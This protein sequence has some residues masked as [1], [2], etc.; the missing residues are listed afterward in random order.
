MLQIHR[1]RPTPR[2]ISAVLIPLALL[3]TSPTRGTAAE[4][5]RLFYERDFLGNSAVI[6]GSADVVVFDLESAER[7]GRN[8]ARYQFDEGSYIFCLG[9]SDP[10]LT[11]LILEDA[12]GTGVVHL[13]RGKRQKSGPRCASVTLPAGSYA[14]RV[15]HDGRKTGDSRRIAFAHPAPKS[16]RLVDSK[17]KPLGGWWALRPDSSLDP[18]IRE[19]RVAVAAPLGDSFWSTTGSM[20]VVRD[21]PT[22][23]LLSSGEVLIAG[24]WGQG[25][26][27]LDSTELYDAVTGQWTSSGPM[28]TVRVFH[29]ATLLPSGQVLVA[30]GWGRRGIITLASA[31][32]YDPVTRQWTPTG[33]MQSAR[34]GHTATL[35][36]GGKVLVA[37]GVDGQGNRLSSAELYDPSTGRW[38]FTADSLGTTH[39]GSATLLPSGDVLFAG[40][41]SLGGITLASAEVYNPAT[42][43]WSPTFQPMNAPRSGHTATL[44]LSGQVLIT[45]GGQ[46]DSAEI[47]DPATRRW[48]LTGSMTTGR[49]N[50]TA[51]LLPTGQVLVLGGEGKGGTPL[52]SAEIY[53]P[54]TRQW[55][56]AES[57]PQSSGARW[58]HSAMFLRSGQVL[59]T[60]GLG[61]FTRPDGAELYDAIRPLSPGFS[62]RQIDNTTLFDFSDVERPTVY[63]SGGLPLNVGPLDSSGYWSGFAS[64]IEPE[65]RSFFANAPLVVDDQGYYRTHIGVRR[66]DGSL[67]N[68]FLRGGGFVLNYRVHSPDPPPAPMT[69]LFRYFPDG[70]QIGAL[71]EGEIAVFQGC[72]YAGQAAVF[73]LDTPDLSTLS[74]GIASLG[75]IGSVKLGANTAVTLYPG[76][77]YQGTGQVVKADASCTDTPPLASASSLRIEPLAPTIL[78]SSKSCVNCRMQN[79]DLSGSDLSGV[80]L[81]GADLSGAVLSNA[82][83]TRVSLEASRL[84]GAR[85][86]HAN[87]ESANLSGAFL[88]S[89][90]AAGV[91]QAASLVGAHM[92][93]VNLAHA[94]LSG[95]N[96]T[97]ATFYGAEPAG[98]SVCHVSSTGSTGNCATAAGAT[99]NSTQFTGAYLY[100]VDFSGDTTIR[101]VN[102]ANAVLIGA[103]FAGARLSRDRD[104]LSDT[105]FLGAFLQGTNLEPASVNEVSLQNAF[106]DFSASNIVV[107]QLD[108]NHTSFPGWA[109]PGQ[110]VCVQ[111]YYHHPTTVP[112][113]NATL[114][115]PDGLA[116][117][118][119]SPPGCGPAVQQNPH[120]NSLMDMTRATPPASYLQDSTY[121]PA[122]VTPVC[123]N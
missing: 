121:V 101:G 6:A 94:Q 29:T 35:L 70:T 10:L 119:N 55:T 62:A 4:N 103:N 27:T 83:L 28:T 91:L 97:D 87:L 122:A 42:E 114:I 3:A 96:L 43:Q 18:E 46:S 77:D 116:A 68:F 75:S 48:E 59:V 13:R 117:D 82:L 44:L 123:G 24:G 80:D 47:Y 17:G 69:V 115:C 107:L 72:N 37:G 33:P 12:T 71:Q 95:A 49:Q 7:S 108:G 110:P 66:S 93:N 14:I 112:D 5:S 109:T 120:W 104:R 88:M 36:P 60:G 89:N 85:L 21:W 105:G 113:G 20:M 61:G 39:T 58:H 22:A 98:Q 79:V 50:H 118:T 63:T 84:F 102:F 51:T 111:A 74:S 76:A 23:T 52:T 67:A 40:G 81:S 45:G 16:P 31:E 8:R 19:G 26:V 2:V 106:L 9:G 15:V 53:D 57:L 41:Q 38:T 78:V 1:F 56:P 54:A 90:P 65:A 34:F 11:A 92:R 99:M 30:G 32:L 25:G 64:A 100:G 73:A 86:D